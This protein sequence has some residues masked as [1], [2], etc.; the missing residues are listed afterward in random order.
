MRSNNTFNRFLSGSMASW[1]EIGLILLLNFLLVPVYLSNWSLEIYSAWILLISVWGISFLLHAGHADFLYH[2]S[3]NF[4]SKNID[5]INVQIISSIPYLLIISLTVVIISFIDIKVN[6]ISNFLKIPI[7]LKET[8]NLSFFYVAIVAILF[9][10]NRIFFQGPLAITGNF[11]FYAWFNFY[12]KLIVSMVPGVT[13]LFGA[14]FE[15]AVKSVLIA[16]FVFST[17]C[18]YFFLT[19]LKKEGFKIYKPNFIIGLKNLISSFWTLLKNI[20]EFFSQTGM[21]FLVSGIYGPIILVYFATTRTVANLLQQAL[22]ALGRPLLPELM[23]YLKNKQEQQVV[24]VFELLYLIILLFLCPLTFFLQLIMP[25]FFEF[26]TL[27]KIAFNPFLY[28]ILTQSILF[29]ALCM[30]AERILTGSNF[31]RLNFF[32]KLAVF[33]IMLFY[34][35]FTRESL[36]IVNVGIAL[37]ISEIF[38]FTSS[39]YFLLKYANDI[40]FKWSIKKLFLP[41]LSVILTFSFNLLMG[42]NYINISLIILSFIIIQL[43]LSILFYKKTS[44]FTKI[45]ISVIKDKIIRFILLDKT[46]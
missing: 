7:D 13:V 45:K 41:L 37:L 32:I 25:Y 29:H 44:Q 40:N 21:R 4:G 17:F 12:H 26:W 24:A 34:I 36:E 39:Y 3:L 10:S 20:L 1:L 9:G 16:E 46:K 23:Y 27:G 18:Y 33:L 35:Y 8:W 5:K 6:F 14:D 28:L 43:F 30:P 22:I 42:I 19:I 11:Q 2:Q 31:Y 15:L 38:L